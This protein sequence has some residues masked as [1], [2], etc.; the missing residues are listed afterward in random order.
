MYRACG[1]ALRLLGDGA[2]GASA[3]AR[4]TYT[5][6]SSDHTLAGVADARAVRGRLGGYDS[7]VSSALEARAE[8]LRASV[9][10]IIL[11]CAIQAMLS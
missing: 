9:F 1:G 3:E 8:P 6:A 10:S 4:V 2:H 5:E 7:R 11:L